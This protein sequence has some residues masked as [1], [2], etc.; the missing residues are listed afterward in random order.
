MEA[1]PKDLSDILLRTREEDLP[2]GV[3]LDDRGEPGK[4]R[5][6]IYVGAAKVACIH[7]TWNMDVPKYYVPFEFDKQKQEIAVLLQRIATT[8]RA[9]ISGE[10][11]EAKDMLRRLNLAIRS[12]A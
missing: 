5:K 10:T 8:T 6:E 7:Q 3:T 4:L 2:S 1:T 11:A 9:R 12:N